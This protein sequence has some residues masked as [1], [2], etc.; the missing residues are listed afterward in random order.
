MKKTNFLIAIRVGPYSPD[1]HD[2]LTL[3][4][5]LGMFFY[6]SCLDSDVFLKLSLRFFKRN[7]RMGC[8]FYNCQKKPIFKTFFSLPRVV[9]MALATTTGL[10]CSCAA[11]AEERAV[12]SDGEQTPSFPHLLSIPQEMETS[13]G[14]RLLFSQSLALS[15]T[16]GCP[17]EVTEEPHHLQSWKDLCP[18]SQGQTQE[19]TSPRSTDVLCSNR[20]AEH[21]V[22]M[23]LQ[24]L[25]PSS[26]KMS[27][28]G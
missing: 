27:D 26:A 5:R 6:N 10:Q 7:W 15:E 17:L 2:S 19:R 4:D 22:R 11:L 8:M 3:W 20:K 14:F 13:A 16:L 12:L 1:H 23:C 24:H 21:R 25:G 18:P 9:C 28:G